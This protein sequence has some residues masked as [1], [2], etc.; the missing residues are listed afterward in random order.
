VRTLTLASCLSALLLCG[1]TDT[2][3]PGAEVTLGEQPV[4][5]LPGGDVAGPAEDDPLPP[6][7]PV[8]TEP[9]E[10]VAAV[11]HAYMPLMPGSH[12][13]YV[14]DEDGLPK[15]EEVRVLAEPRMVFGVPCTAVVEHIF[16][17]GE[18]TEM[19]THY[20]AQDILGNV[21]RFGEQSIEFEDGQGTITEDSW[22]AGVAGALPWIT[23]SAD[24]QVG[25][26][27]SDGGNEEATVLA[28][29]ATA[30]AP[31]GMFQGCL[32]VEET[33]PE[34]PED[35]D[36][37]IY[38]PGVGLVSEESPTGRIDLVSYTIE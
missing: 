28:V 24:P 32:E 11:E 29:D 18:L 17:E 31:A 36:R 26:I 16:V 23:L 4:V 30:L 14:G 6:E 10:Y 22:E 12:W 20:L 21:W 33:N 1:C 13:S 25:D 8:V 19:T 38:A 2:S 5:E 35:K 27:F 37:I 34:D 3:D 9:S 15:R 7:P